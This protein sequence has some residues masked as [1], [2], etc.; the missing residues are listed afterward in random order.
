[1]ALV[2][3]M[4]KANMA[5]RRCSEDNYFLT[6]WSQQ[7][8]LRLYSEFKSFSLPVLKS[9]TSLRQSRTHV[10]SPRSHTSHTDIKSFCSCFWCF[11]EF[12]GRPCW[13]EILLPNWLC[14]CVKQREC[15]YMCVCVWEGRG[16]GGLVFGAG[17]RSRRSEGV[18]SHRGKDACL[19]FASQGLK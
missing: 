18:Y 16:A 6:F 12:S 13:P 2:P 17:G 14:V 8:V 9:V 15:I 3:L 19:F 4:M 5:F 10:N 1:M 11:L 7:H